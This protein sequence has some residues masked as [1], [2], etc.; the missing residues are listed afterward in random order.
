ML[1]TR[2]RVWQRVASSLAVPVVGRVTRV[3]ADTVALLP[4]GVSTPVSLSRQAITRVEVSAGPGTGSATNSAIRGAIVGALGG[5]VLGTIAGNL[6]KRNAAKLAIAG[7]GVGGGLG[8]GVGAALPGEA[9]RNAPLP[10]TP[11][12]PD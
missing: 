7:F 4:D 8:A 2:A 1:G 6:A 3:G 5:A 11:T 12:P 10:T 9:W